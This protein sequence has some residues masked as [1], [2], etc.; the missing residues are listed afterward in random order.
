MY[1]QV[2]YP[3]NLSVSIGLS[4][5]FFDGQLVDKNI[6]NP[7]LGLQYDLTPDTTLRAA[8]FRVLKRTLLENQTLEPTQVAGFNQFF[9]D[10]PATESIRY[11]VAIDNKLSENANIGAE[12]SKRKVVKKRQYLL[13]S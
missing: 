5:D 12:V 10:P 8:V 2:N 1:S 4:V 9:D 3:A 7:K 11:G 6:V 13:A